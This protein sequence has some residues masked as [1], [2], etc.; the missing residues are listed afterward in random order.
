MLASNGEITPPCGVP[1]TVAATP[2]LGQHPASQPRTDQL[3]HP[4]VRDPSA[5][6][7]RATAR[8]RCCRR[9]P[10]Y[11]PRP[12]QCTPAVNATRMLSSACSRRPLRP[13]PV[14]ST[15]GSRPRRSVPARSSPPAAPP[16]RAP[17]G[18]PTAACRR[19]V[20]GSPP[21]DRRGT[22]RPARRSAGS[23]P[24]I[25]ST[26]Y[27]STIAKV[28][29]STPAAPRFARTRFHASHRTS[30][31]WIR[32]YRAW[33]RRPSDCL[34]AAHSLRCSCRTFAPTASP[35]ALRRG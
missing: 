5:D 34:A 19:L 30:P 7:R 17:S 21:P 1:A 10:G 4:P 6:H 27:S 25:R 2:L 29:R 22:I 9:S 24:S 15:A 18:Y 16:G 3:E 28:T 35:Q 14:T 26:P 32:S 33:K 23:S 31:L 12:Q 20:S 13:E 11:R 8:G